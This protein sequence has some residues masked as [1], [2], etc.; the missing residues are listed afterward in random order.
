MT[1]TRLMSERFPRASAYHPDWILSAVSGGANPLW[2]TEWLTEAMDLRPG[3][4]VLDLG[5]GRA[6]SSIF[7][8][9][10]FGVQVWATDLW[11]SATENRNRI[12]DAGVAGGVFPIHADARSLPFAN[13]F[14]DAIVSIDSYFYY[15]TDDL[16]LNDVLR[17]LKPGGL[18]GIAGAA[19][20][21]EVGES[22]P[23]HLRAW[24]TP[25]C[26]CLHSADWWRRHWA[27][28]G[29]VDV[30][31]ADSLDD[32]WQYWLQWLQLVAPENSTEIHA[33]EADRGRYFGYARAI[34]RR[35]ADA[36]ISDPIT[37]VPT[38][39]TRQPVLRAD[40]R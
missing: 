10:E 31:L 2:L 32:G 30:E 11:C 3:M 18:L 27:R 17:Y 36:C 24:W 19:M 6:L 13:Q 8:H 35:R 14:F 4:K 38:Q 34:A 23:D 22:L 28:S 15:G 37:S 29:S 1:D 39:Y 7:L 20:L 16:F 33:L 25:D 12:D 40:M 26:C 5:C 9:R 21:Q